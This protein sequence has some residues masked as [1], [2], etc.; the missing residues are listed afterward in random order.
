VKYYTH[1]IFIVVNSIPLYQ[2]QTKDHISYVQVGLVLFA[3]GYRTLVVTFLPTS[4]GCWLAARAL[5][6]QPQQQPS[7]SLNPNHHANKE[8]EERSSDTPAR[9]VQ[10]EIYSNC[11]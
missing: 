2:L 10:E 8:Q 1:H 3:E 4:G 7:T 11:K 9:D 6:T 5:S